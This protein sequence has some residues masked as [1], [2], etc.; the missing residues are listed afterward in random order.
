[1]M[2]KIWLLTSQLVVRRAGTIKTIRIYDFR[3]EKLKRLLQLYYRRR[4]RFALGPFTLELR[5]QVKL[6]L[7]VHRRR[8]SFW[9]SVLTK[10]FQW[11]KRQNIFTSFVGLC[12]HSRWLWGGER[13]RSAGTARPPRSARNRYSAGAGSSRR[14]TA[15]PDPALYGA[16]RRT[17]RPNRVTNVP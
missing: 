1:M 11:L 4:G 14:R 13:G 10:W 8:V 7:Q 9:T 6:H 3:L 12:L 17:P 5:R 16:R 2:K 15:P